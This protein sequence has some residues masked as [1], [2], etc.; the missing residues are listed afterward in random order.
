MVGVMFFHLPVGVMTWDSGAEGGAPWALRW[1]TRWS[2]AALGHKSGSPD[3]LCPIFFT[4]AVLLGRE[5]QRN[6]IYGL[7]VAFSGCG[8]K[9]AAA[10][11]EGGVFEAEQCYL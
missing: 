2:R 8:R 3:V 7:G 5:Y 4:D 9:Y 1:S 10:I 6:K 11:N